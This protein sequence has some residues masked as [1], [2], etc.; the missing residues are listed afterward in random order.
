MSLNA[1]YSITETNCHLMVEGDCN[2]FA[3]AVAQQAG[4]ALLTAL[5]V[6]TAEIVADYS[7][8]AF[9]YVV[10]YMNYQKMPLKNPEEMH[11]YLQTKFITETAGMVDELQEMSEELKLI[12]A[13]LWDPKKASGFVNGYIASME[14]EITEGAIPKVKEICSSLHHKIGGQ[15]LGAFQSCV[16]RLRGYFRDQ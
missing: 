1:S 6:Q 11:Q 4:E 3:A 7:T 12:N 5:V 9:S 2:T 16:V 13:T 15:V 8:H 14:S 10:N